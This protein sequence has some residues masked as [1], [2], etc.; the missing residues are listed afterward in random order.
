MQSELEFEDVLTGIGNENQP[1]G[2]STAWVVLTPAAELLPTDDA[3]LAKVIEELN[4]IDADLVK[5]GI[6]K[7]SMTIDELRTLREAQ[8]KTSKVVEHAAFSSRELA[9]LFANYIAGAEDPVEMMAEQ[10]SCEID[11]YREH[12]YRGERPFT[13]LLQ[14][15][16]IFEYW[17]YASPW[18][19]ELDSIDE[20]AYTVNGEHEQMS[21][22]FWSR[23]SSGAIKLA[24]A[25]WD[26][27]YK[28]GKLTK[29]VAAQ[30]QL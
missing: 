26:K 10:I 17:G 9:I 28:L 21:G 14:D 7:R 4:E 19:V 18:E 11:Q 1:S 13:V 27:L 20:I 29:P 6:V 3:S 24:E 5:H 25:Y 16:G 15:G 23:H 8:N 22:T 2:S 30:D 12:L